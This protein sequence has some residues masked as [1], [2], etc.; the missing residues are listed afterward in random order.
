[1]LQV[2]IAFAIAFDIKYSSL[3]V[4]KDLSI[5]FW[6]SFLNGEPE[7]GQRIYQCEIVDRYCPLSRVGFH[8]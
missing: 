6:Q 7:A 4:D 3:V 5:I 2:K 1:M 8:D